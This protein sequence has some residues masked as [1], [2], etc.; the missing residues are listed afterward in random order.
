MKKKTKSVMQ[1]SERLWVER[2]PTPTSCGPTCLHA[3][4]RWYHEVISLAELIPAIPSL[5]GGGT[6]AV[7]MGIDALS[8]GYQADLYS[9]NLR[10]LDPSWFP[11]TSTSIAGKLQASRRVRSNKKERL[12]LSALET[13]VTN[14]GNLVMTALTRAL[15]RKHLLLGRPILAG[16]SA[17]FLY[18]VAREISKTGK[19]DDLAGNPEG[20]FVVL[21]G[22]D[23]SSKMVTVHDPYPDAPFDGDHQYMVHID[24]LLNAIL[25]GILTH[26]SNILVIHK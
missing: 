4:Y 22:Y 21:H 20:H 8:R 13:F 25:L 12:E 19:P 23:S 17:T 10:V 2:Q 9:S 11:G 26:D 18:W 3:I 24:R 7:H 16:L 14:G 15:L 6:L 5:H 1:T